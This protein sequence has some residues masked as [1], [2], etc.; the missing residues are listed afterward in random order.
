MYTE[1]VVPIG[2]GGEEIVGEVERVEEHHV[3][4]VVEAGEGL[5]EEGE[6]VMEEEGGG[7]RGCSEGGR[8]NRGGGT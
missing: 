8:D 5:E 1:E 6:E 4:G 3:L 2:E 7:G